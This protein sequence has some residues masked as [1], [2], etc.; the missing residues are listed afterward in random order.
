MHRSEFDVGDYGFGTTDAERGLQIMAQFNTAMRNLYGSYNLTVNDL[1]NRYGSNAIDTI[2][3]AA[4][5]GG[6]SWFGDT[7]AM[8]DSQTNNAMTA[9][10]RNG[11]GKAPLNVNS[12]T[13]ALSAVASDPSTAANIW[14]AIAYTA[15]NTAGDIVTGIQE[16]GD[17]ILDVVG[18]AKTTIDIWKWTL[19]L[20]P[21]VLIWIAWKNKETFASAAAGGALKIGS[22]AT[23]KAIK[24]IS[25]E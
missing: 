12:F 16:G 23:K 14:G 4:S 25:E 5:V 21:A 3:F 17:T 10:A 18:V 11:G 8:T 24:A 20:V 13:S 15:W 22:A 6:T 2:G 9:L 19:L 7:A 1:V